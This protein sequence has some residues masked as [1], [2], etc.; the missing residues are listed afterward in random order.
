[1][2][3]SN[4]VYIGALQALA[5]LRSTATGKEKATIDFIAEAIAEKGDRDRGNRP[6]PTDALTLDELRKMDGEPVWI[7]SL[8]DQTERWGLVSLF[9]QATT[10]KLYVY[11]YDTGHGERNLSSQEYGMTWLAYRCKPEEEH[12]VWM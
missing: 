5:A 11:I 6:E 9:R 4:N 2:K 8:T 12:H 3:Y 1:M 10:G 7:K